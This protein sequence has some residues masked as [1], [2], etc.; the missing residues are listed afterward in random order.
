MRHPQW[1]CSRLPNETAFN[2]AWSTDKGFFEFM[3]DDVNKER[4]ER[5]GHAFRPTE[6]FSSVSSIVNCKCCN[7]SRSLSKQTD[8]RLTIGFP[9][10]TLSKDAI[11]VDV[12]GGSGRAMRILVERFKHLKYIVQDLPQVCE[13]SRE[14]SLIT[15]SAVLQLSFDRTRYQRTQE[16]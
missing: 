12:G 10:D 14:A 8:I 9:W 7:N 1:A 2:A 4:L 11:V 13:R 15:I 5:L 6:Q 16:Q 3:Q